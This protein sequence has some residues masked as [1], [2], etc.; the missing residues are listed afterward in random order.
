MSARG[1]EEGNVGRGSRSCV[2]KDRRDGQMSMKMNRNPK[3]MGVRRYGASPRK[4][5]VPG[6]GT[7]QE[8]MGVTLAVTHNIGYMEAEEAITCSQAGTPVEQ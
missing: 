8:P 2:G 3:L 7:A 6:K 4:H 5:S 1:D